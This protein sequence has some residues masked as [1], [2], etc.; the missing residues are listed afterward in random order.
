MLGKIMGHYFWAEFVE[1][2]GDIFRF[3]T[4]I[5][6]QPVNEI[7]ADDICIGAIVGKNPGSAKS[8]ALGNGI[9]PI[10]LDGDKLLPTVRNIVYNAYQAAKMDIPQQGYIQVLNSFY[11]CDPDLGSAIN[12][13]KNNCNVESCPA[14]SKIFPWVWYVW[15]GDS[16]D[17][18]KFKE[19]FQ[20]IKAK[21]H[22][23]F[24][25][26]QKE[27]IS[28]IPRGTD[29]AKHTQGLRHDYI[30]PYITSLIKNG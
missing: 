10:D 26:D 25:K 9:S 4:R 5:Y 28:E 6:L 14:E 21:K 19:R 15:G 30:V 22:F 13:L 20:D 23:Y 2:E 17:L 11:L 7:R 8:M 16:I 27:I 1:I 18:N 24:D 12:R 3:D 29:F